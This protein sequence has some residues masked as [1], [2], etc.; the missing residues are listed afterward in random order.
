MKHFPLLFRIPSQILELVSGD[1]FCCSLDLWRFVSS[2]LFAQ[3]GINSCVGFLPCSLSN[4]VFPSRPLR[5]LDKM[6][7]A[8][9]TNHSKIDG[10]CPFDSLYP[11]TASSVVSSALHIS[12]TRFL[13]AIFARFCVALQRDLTITKQINEFR[14]P[15]DCPRLLD[16]FLQRNAAHDDLV[17]VFFHP[18][19]ASFIF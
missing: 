7:L 13:N 17:S 18:M 6:H 9:S 10:S 1:S 19:Q 4:G 12:A 16:S 14:H 3:T 11:F 2:T 15:F 5:Q 8:C